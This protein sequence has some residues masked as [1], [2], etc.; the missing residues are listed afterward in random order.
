MPDDAGRTVLLVEDDADNRELMT[1]VLQSSGFGVVAAAGG[2]EAVAMLRARRFDVVVT[3]V[4]M[5][6]VGGLAVARAAKAS[7]PDVPVLV[8]TGYSER[9][10][11][12]A[13]EGK[14]VDRV[15]VKPVDPDVL[16]AAIRDVLRGR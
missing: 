1:E 10:D 14:E 16:V 12:T 4:G 2:A 5:P 9:D 15:L 11:L 7:R 3:D 8:V 13:A 6:G